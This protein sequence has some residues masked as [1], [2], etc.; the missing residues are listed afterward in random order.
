LLDGEDLDCVL[1]A[2]AVVKRRRIT[3][4]G[5]P[6]DLWIRAAEL[7]WRASCPGDGAASCTRSIYR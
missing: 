3:G 7:G 4:S 2:I 6:D 1:E 5:S